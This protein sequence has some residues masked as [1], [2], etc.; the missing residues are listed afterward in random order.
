MLTYI[1]NLGEKLKNPDI[2]KKEKDEILDDL[3]N[4]KEASERIIWEYIKREQ[5]NTKSQRECIECKKIIEH[6]ENII[7]KI[8]EILNK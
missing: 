1:E 6:E 4:E 3:R 7:K 2:S 5:I 8:K